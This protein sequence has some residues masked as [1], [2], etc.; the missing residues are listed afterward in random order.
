MKRQVKVN[1]RDSKIMGKYK[2]KSSAFNHWAN[3]FFIRELFVTL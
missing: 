1:E 3:D 2:T